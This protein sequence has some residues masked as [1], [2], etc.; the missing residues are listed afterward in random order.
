MILV[1]SAALLLTATSLAA[2]APVCTPGA[3]QWE[4]LEF[5]DES[6]SSKGPMYY[7]CSVTITHTLGHFWTHRLK[8]YGKTLDI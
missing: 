8:G 6:N 4:K 3:A 5:S 2:A 7:D 1:R